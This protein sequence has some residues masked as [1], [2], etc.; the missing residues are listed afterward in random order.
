MKQAHLIPNAFV[1]IASEVCELNNGVVLASLPH[2]K[3]LRIRHWGIRNRTAF[4]AWKS[5]LNG[6]PTDIT[7]T[8]TLTD[9]FGIMQPQHAPTRC[10]EVLSP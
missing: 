7:H 6:P 9:T 4:L 8:H 1:C 10:K 3:V 2:P 5:N